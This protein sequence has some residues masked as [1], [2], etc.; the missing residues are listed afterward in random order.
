MQS[1][2]GSA[3]RHVEQA[4][5]LGKGGRL[6][7][8]GD[9]DEALLEPGHVDGFPLQAL[10]GMEGGDLDGVGRVVVVGSGLGAHPGLKAGGRAR[11]VD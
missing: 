6:A 10:G 3:Q 7:G 11:G 5:L 4:A 9:R 8:V 1:H 2:L